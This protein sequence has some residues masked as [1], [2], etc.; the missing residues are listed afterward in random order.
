MNFSKLAAECA[1][2]DPDKQQEFL[3]NVL[4]K[5]MIDRLGRGSNLPDANAIPVLV[6]A[7]EP[8]IAQL[9]KENSSLAMEILDAFY[10]C[11]SKNLIGNPSFDILNLRSDAKKYMEEVIAKRQ[12][13]ER[14]EANHQ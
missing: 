9:I 8:S 12:E 11:I 6:N 7:H 3:S 13:I 4:L 5:I 1:G 2:Q 10:K 14:E